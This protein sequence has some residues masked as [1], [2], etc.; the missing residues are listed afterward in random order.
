MFYLFFSFLSYFS[1]CVDR[2]TLM[3]F[4]PQQ[5]RSWI[6]TTSLYVVKFTW[7]SKF[8][9]YA[10]NNRT[11]YFS[12]M[13]CWLPLITVCLFSI[14]TIIIHFKFL[15]C[16]RTA[17]LH[18]FYD[19]FYGY[20]VNWMISKMHCLYARKIYT[21]SYLYEF[22]LLYHS[23]PYHF[24]VWLLLLLLVFWI[25]HGCAYTQKERQRRW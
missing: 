18:Y 5:R 6:H 12:Q 25:Q 2:E 10:N 7:L 1:L 14:Y 23:T 21:L 15:K 22:S 8:S 3:Y 4:F 24:L 16:F 9:F 20:G 11:T 19:Y 17:T 13:F